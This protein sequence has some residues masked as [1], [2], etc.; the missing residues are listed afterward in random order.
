MTH[1]FEIEWPNIPW[2][3]PIPVSTFAPDGSPVHR[4]ACRICIAEKGMKPF[5]VDSLP[6]SFEDVFIHIFTEHP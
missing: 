6:T 3:T 2:R 5:E 4:F 1:P